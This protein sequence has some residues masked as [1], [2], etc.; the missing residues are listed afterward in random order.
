MATFKSFKEFGATVEAMNKAIERDRKLWALE[1]AKRAQEIATAQASADLGGDPKFSG[2]KPPLDTHI[3][4]TDTGA[5]LLPTRS[6]AGPW[7]VANQGRHTGNAGGFSGP[8]INRKTGHT[9]RTKSGGVRKVKAGKGRRWNG[10]TKG[11]HTADHA[12]AKMERE[13]PRIGERGL[14]RT[15]RRYFDVD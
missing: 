11:F 12:V 6:G 2:W 9:A 10:V 3:K 7:T 8:G 1:M 15:E 14:L 4:P 13:L 5:V